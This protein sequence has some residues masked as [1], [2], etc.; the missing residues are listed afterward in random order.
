MQ[1]MRVRSLV[2]EDPLE[3]AMAAYSRVLAGKIHGFRR[4]A[5]YSPW[6]CKESDMTDATEQAKL[7]NHQKKNRK[8]NSFFISTKFNFILVVMCVNIILNIYRSHLYLFDSV[9]I[10]VVCTFH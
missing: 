5:V 7:S 9:L 2:W 8:N 1:D 3:E 4:L 6:G 10:N